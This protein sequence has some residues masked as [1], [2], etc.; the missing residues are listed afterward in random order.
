MQTK[1]SPLAVYCGASKGKNAEYAAAARAL[2]GVMAARGIGLV[3]GGGRVGLM[4]EVA[5]AAMAGGGSVIG[6][7]THEL[8]RREVA[9]DGVTDLRIVDTM[10][11]RKKAMADLAR[12][13]IALP[14]GVGTLDELFEIMAWSQLAIHDHP[15]GVLNT[16]G[17]FDGLLAF[18]EQASEDGFLRTDP[19]EMLVVGS[20]PGDLLDRMAGYV[21]PR[22]KPL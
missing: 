12:G 11:E 5:D 22:R 7:I 2:G 15:I 14:G 1:L 4:G 16:C 19:R 9:H 3:Y 18:L 8:V 6:I 21:P 17:F 10:H 13:F 20:D